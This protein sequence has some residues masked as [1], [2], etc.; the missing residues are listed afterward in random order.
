VESATDASPQPSPPSTIHALVLSPLP[1]SPWGI[2]QPSFKGPPLR[3]PDPLV[4]TVVPLCPSSRL[5]CSSMPF[6]QRYSAAA[7]LDADLQLPEQSELAL[8]VTFGILGRQSVLL[9]AYLAACPARSPPWTPKS[10]SRSFGPVAGQLFV[11]PFASPQIN[12]GT[13]IE[14]RRGRHA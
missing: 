2:S 6:L 14:G 9:R 7:V 8:P 3:P 4:L 13:Q 5:S 1:T 10:C 12:T 11:L